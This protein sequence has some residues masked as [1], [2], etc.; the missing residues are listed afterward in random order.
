ML[1]SLAALTVACANSGETKVDAAPARPRVCDGAL[2]STYGVMP[3]KNKTSK[4]IELTGTDDVITT[5]MSD[6]RCFTLVERDKVSLLIEEMKLCSDKN[7]DVEYFKCD[8]FA[9]KGNL[10]GV[11]RMVV[12]DVIHFEESVKGADIV[13]KLPGIGGAEA[14]VSYSFVALSIRVLDTES[15]TVLAS[16]DVHAMVP[17]DKAG[18]SLSSG[19]AGGNLKL[20]AASRTPM[21]DA[22]NAMIWEAVK[23]LSVAAALKG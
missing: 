13:A 15:G 18:V 17:A 19:P 4:N 23:R 16:T 2:P 9:K 6:S 20:L 1:I 21:G 14:G 7:P 5:A 8:S 10:L 3:L 12:G 22:L 11:R